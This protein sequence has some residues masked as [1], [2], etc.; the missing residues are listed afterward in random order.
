MS[1]LAGYKTYICAGVGAIITCAYM[2]GLI[3][4]NTWQAGMAL[5]GFGGMAAL[6][7]SV[8]KV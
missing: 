2:I 7:A 6:R 5:C 8:K 3:D 4:I 1:M